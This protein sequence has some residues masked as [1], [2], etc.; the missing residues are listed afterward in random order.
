MLTPDGD[1][2]LDSGKASRW[3]TLMGR[4]TSACDSCALYPSCQGRKCPLFTIKQNR[5]PCP[6]DREMYET[7]VKLVAFG[8]AERVHE[9]TCDEAG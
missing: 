9:P 8:G 4:D 3:T 1:L 2:Q 6:F 7:L 5:P